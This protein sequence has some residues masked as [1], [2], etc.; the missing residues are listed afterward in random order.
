M[1]EILTTGRA[2]GKQNVPRTRYSYRYLPVGKP[3]FSKIFHAFDVD[4]VEAFRCDLKKGLKFM[5]TKTR[6]VH[7][8]FR[9]NGLGIGKKVDESKRSLCDDNNRRTVMCSG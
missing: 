4:R 9:S 6:R 3:R 5:K 8:L 2:S 7:L 1:K